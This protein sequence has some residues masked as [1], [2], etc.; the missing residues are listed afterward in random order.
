MKSITNEAKRNDENQ[1]SKF[2]SR[3]KENYK[4]SPCFCPNCCQDYQ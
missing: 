2:E 1:F 3:I 4:T